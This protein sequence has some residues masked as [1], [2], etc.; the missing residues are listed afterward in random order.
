MKRVYLAIIFI[1]AASSC[2]TVK[3]IPYLKNGK[4]WDKSI[5]VLGDWDGNPETPYTY[6]HWAPVN[7]G[8]DASGEI[9][10][11]D[12]HRC[13]RLYQWGA[14]D[15]ETNKLA[16]MRYYDESKPKFWYSGIQMEVHYNGNRW[17]DGQ[18]PCPKGWRLPTE[19]ELSCLFMGRLGAYG[20][21]ESGQYAGKK[22]YAGAEYFGLNDDLTP[23]R[24][25]FL[26]AAGY[27]QGSYG[28]AFDFG[29]S[30]GYWSAEAERVNAG[31]VGDGA[32][33]QSP[34]LIIS[35]DECTIAQSRHASGY[36][37]RCVHDI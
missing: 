19:Q 17:R 21:T 9:A 24:G 7:A 5:V 10:T 29:E 30:G 33:A 23:G 6:L 22:A 34:A 25:V 12:D 1:I 11:R 37:V 27:I 36:S 18:G 35:K 14:D 28:S 8:F 4:K 2:D 26:P 31:P 20:W 32:R 3:P 15:N 13:G 16:K